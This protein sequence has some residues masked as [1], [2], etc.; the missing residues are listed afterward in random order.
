MR[1]HLPPPAD[2]LISQS[3]S[4]IGRRRRAERKIREK[5]GMRARIKCQNGF[6]FSHFVSR[7]KVSRSVVSLLLAWNRQG[8]ASIALVEFWFMKFWQKMTFSCREKLTIQSEFESNDKNAPT[9]VAF[10][11]KLS[12]VW[13]KSHISPI[14]NQFPQSILFSNLTSWNQPSTRIESTPW[15]ITKTVNDEEKFDPEEKTHNCRRIRKRQ[16][17]SLNPHSMGCAATHQTDWWRIKFSSR[18]R[19]VHPPP[20]VLSSASQEDFSIMESSKSVWSAW[21]CI[22]LTAATE[23]RQ[24]ALPRITQK[25][26]P[27]CVIRHAWSINASSSHTASQ[28][29]LKLFFPPENAAK[30]VF[31][32]AAAAVKEDNSFPPKTLSKAIPRA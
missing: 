20:K 29:F 30:V 31:H 26:K 25:S 28:R 12:V 3:T 22:R 11:W 24:I 19:S 1:L 4:G 7:S 18:R 32:P 10:I 13:P 14:F 8:F 15:A 2:S 6:Q 23:V 27:T 9:Q 5:S 16:I 17:L 21:I